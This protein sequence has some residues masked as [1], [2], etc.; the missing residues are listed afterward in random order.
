MPPAVQGQAAQLLQAAR[1]PTEAERAF[2][3][4]RKKLI[5]IYEEHNPAKLGEVGAILERF[6]GREA[7]LFQMLEEKY[8]L[9]SPGAGR[10]GQAF[11]GRYSVR[12]PTAIWAAMP[13]QQPWPQ[14]ATACRGACHGRW[15]W[16]TWSDAPCSV[17][18]WDGAWT[19]VCAYSSGPDSVG[20]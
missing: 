12:F 17:R 5:D 4:R 14:G 13:P 20:G 1:Q 10:W 8:G 9:A 19:A 2:Q 7:T 11:A 16:S 18:C 3:L 15:C 6:E